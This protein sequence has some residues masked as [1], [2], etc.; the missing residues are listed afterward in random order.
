MGILISGFYRSGVQLVCGGID[1]GN[2]KVNPN[3]I[4]SENG[5]W[6]ERVAFLGLNPKK[7]KHDTLMDMWN[8]PTLS[9]T[10]IPCFLHPK[11]WESH[12]GISTSS[13]YIIL[14]VY[15][16]IEQVI[17]SITRHGIKEMYLQKKG[18]G[19]MRAM[20]KFN[21]ILPQIQQQT[22]ASYIDFYQSIMEFSQQYKGKIIHFKSED[23]INEFRNLQD[24][25]NPGLSE[26]IEL[27]EKYFDADLFTKHRSIDTYRDKSL[28]EISLF[29]QTS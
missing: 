9:E 20:R 27:D 26:N 2:G 7:E 13:E 29:F 28:N 18:F 6:D 12:L 5:V 21:K 24:K 23:F 15:R 11:Y 10:F 8:N 19:R 16:P 17:D 25:I 22:K 3:C 14:V 4:E 1:T